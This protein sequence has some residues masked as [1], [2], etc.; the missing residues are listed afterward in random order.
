MILKLN[1]G[2]HSPTNTLNSLLVLILAKVNTCL[3][4]EQVDN[5]FNKDDVKVLTT[6]MPLVELTSNMPFCISRMYC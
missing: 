4:L 5:V 6:K 2:L 3:F 1:L